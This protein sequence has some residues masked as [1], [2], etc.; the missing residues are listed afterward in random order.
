MI[1]LILMAVQNTESLEKATE[2]IDS[3]EKQI[4]ELQDTIISTQNDKIS[5]L[6]GD[7]SS[8]VGVFGL[9]L[10]VISFLSAGVII[11]IQYLNRKAT[12]NMTKAKELAQEARDLSAS[13]NNIN[14]DAANE[15]KMVQKKITELG[16]LTELAKRHNL[17]NVKLNR[18]HSE[19]DF[20]DQLTASE[21]PPELK[22]ELDTVHIKLEV[23][24]M[25]SH[26]ESAYRTLNI[27]LD[28]FYTVPEEELY[29]E[30][31]DK[32][33]G[34]LL[35]ILDSQIS[36]INNG[37]EDLTNY[38]QDI[39]TETGQNSKSKENKLIEDESQSKENE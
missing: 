26:I 29:Q 13:G 33:R 35:T 17:A 10:A 34:T 39:V 18:A 7:I 11:Y 31:G 12:E 5:A 28:T 4:T 38:V 15:L 20:I 9:I 37:V 24:D 3:L 25:V 14:K 32:Y 21:L 30:N 6:N 19:K 23:A 2:Q 22:K 1:N 36:K 16:F 27:F 8:I